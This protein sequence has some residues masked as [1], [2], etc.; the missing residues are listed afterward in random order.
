MNEK[1]SKAILAI[2]ILSFTVCDVAAQQSADVKEPSQ[3]LDCHRDRN[4][5]SNEGIISSQA[6]CYGCH[7]EPSSIEVFRNVKVS[8]QVKPEYFKDSSHRYVACTQCHTD[9]A[10][11]PHRSSEGVQC[12]QCHMN[13][14]GKA[15]THAEHMRV[16]CEACHVDSPFV[17]YDRKTNEIKLSRTNAASEPIS[18]S[19]HKT[20]NVA[21]DSFCRKCHNA[22]NRVGAPP[23]VVPHKSFLCIVCHYS[24][25]ALGSALFLIPLMIACI[26]GIAILVFWFRSVGYDTPTLHQKIQT[27]SEAV[28]DAILSREIFRVA[29][30]FLLDV[31]LQRRILAN[32]LS[33]WFSHSFIFYPF[34]ARFVV[35]LCTLILHT[36]APEARLTREL[37]NKDNLFMLLFNDTT[38]LLMLLGVGWAMGRRY[39]T[40][41]R[42]VLTQEQDTLALVI[43][44]AVALTGFLIEATRICLCEI[45]ARFAWPA[46]VS[47]CLAWLFSA[48]HFPCQAMF[49]YA[50]G[51]H[52]LS[53]SLLIAYL[54]F[55]KL[56]HIFITALSLTINYKKE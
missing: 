26:G 23:S 15:G 42:H 37:V 49:G 22:N 4:L 33:Q 50:W 1:I 48:L 36:A 10:R 53:W 21:G 16:R 27:A 47:Y 19:Q 43:I 5:N 13:F 7:N 11:S 2:I 34:L 54:P 8:M 12:R 41:P 18:L 14:Y 44:G 45:P 38:G 9:I 17:E 30:T 29:K 25:F 20:T 6:F 51:M 28:W 56:K 55:G 39:I 24:P 3:C 52:A 32:G 46:Y 31:L 35:S 40:K